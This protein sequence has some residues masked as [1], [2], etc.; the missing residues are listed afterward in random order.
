M[1]AIAEQCID[2]Q[3]SS[4]AFYQVKLEPDARYALVAEL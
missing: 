3:H 2:K 4:R 1:E